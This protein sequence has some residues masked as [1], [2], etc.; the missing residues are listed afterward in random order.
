MGVAAVL[1]K[2]FEVLYALICIAK[3]VTFLTRNQL[4]L[5]DLE[6]DSLVFRI[7][8]TSWQKC[9]EVVLLVSFPFDLVLL[10]DNNAT[11]L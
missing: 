7:V 3:V 9:D 10:E 8:A 2:N 4:S 5:L 6:A 11:S 1:K